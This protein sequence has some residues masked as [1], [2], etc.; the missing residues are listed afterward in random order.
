MAFLRLNGRSFKGYLGTKYIMDNI[1]VGLKRVS[2]KEQAD[3]YSLESQGKGNDHYAIKEDLNIKKSFT[4]HE[5]ASK[6]EQ[7]KTF[8]E[9][10]A[11]VERHDIKH[12]ICEKV[13]RFSRSIKEAKLIYDWLQEDEKRNIHFIKESL[14]VNKFSKS[15]DKLNLNIKVALAQFYADNL[16]EEVKKGQQEKLE[17]KWYPSG[18]KFGYKA[19]QENS[20]HILIPDG[21]TS[22]LLKRALELFSTGNYSVKT[23]SEKM[24]GDG[25]RSKKG[26]KVATGRLYAYLTDPFYYGQFFWNGQL[27]EGKHTPLIS[28]Q[29]YLR[30]QSLLK[31]KNAPKYTLH[32]HLF[33]GLTECVSCSHSITWETQKGKLY[34]YC[35]GYKNCSQKGSVKEADINPKIIESLGKLEIKNKRLSEWVRK[36]I[37]EGH[38]DEMEY[39]ED[40]IKQLEERLSQAQKRLDNL[41]DMRV[42]EQIDG[43]TY[44]KKFKQYSEEKDKI[45]ESINQH[46]HLQVKHVKYSVAFYELSQR[47]RKIYYKAKPDGKRDLVELVFTSIPV[48]INTM[49]ITPVYTKPFEILA[50]L[51]RLT[52]NSNVEFKEDTKDATF[53]LPEKDDMTVQTNEFLHAHPELRRG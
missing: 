11:Y 49:A 17:Q 53:E 36:A 50:E 3:G 7:R 19:V 51:V 40:V 22:T 31:R 43:G 42:D 30:N 47:A 18:K 16:S 4:I 34:G 15:H 38:Q 8:M 20:K 23:L 14:V 10:M 5:S 46:S 29:I 6:S 48:E 52:N 1:A 45:T 37:K 2:T 21:T 25:L 33:K 24:Y 44:K 32:A 9:M 41:L 27:Y 13:D 39:Q 28:E 12:I 26:F 35:N